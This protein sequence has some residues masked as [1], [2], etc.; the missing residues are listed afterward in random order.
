MNLLRRN[1]NLKDRA[2]SHR[3]TTYDI[4]TPASLD[5]WTRVSVVQDF[6][7]RLEKAIRGDRLAGHVEP[8]LAFDTRRPVLF[9][10]GSDT[11]WPYVSEALVDK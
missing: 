10:I 9:V 3:D 4:V 8:I 5:Q 6:A 11:W 7:Q 1:S 2:E